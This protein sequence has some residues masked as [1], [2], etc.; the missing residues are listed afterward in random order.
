M[1]FDLRLTMAKPSNGLQVCLIG[2]GISVGVVLFLYD[3]GR[4]TYDIY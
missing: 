1:R 3:Y 4:E 2:S